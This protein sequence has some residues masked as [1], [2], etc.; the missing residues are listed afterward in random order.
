MIPAGTPAYMAPEQT[1]RDTARLGPGPTFICWRDSLLSAQ[2]ASP[3]GMTSEDAFLPRGRG[4]IT[5]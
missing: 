1:D 2:G 5:L 3:R 4:N